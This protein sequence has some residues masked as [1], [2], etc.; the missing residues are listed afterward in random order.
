MVKIKDKLKGFR[1]RLPKSKGG[2]I[3]IIT[4]SICLITFT[5][6]FANLFY[7]GNIY[8][9]LEKPEQM[10]DTT[11]HKWNKRKTSTAFFVSD[12]TYDGSSDVPFIVLFQILFF[13]IYYSIFHSI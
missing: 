5:G 6:I 7:T 11:W 10:D 1:L 12:T 13:H 3:V 8:T 4:A 9:V 2:K